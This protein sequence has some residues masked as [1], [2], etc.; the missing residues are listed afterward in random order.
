MQFAGFF[1]LAL[2]YVL[3]IANNYGFRKT[4]EKVKNCFVGRDSAKD[5]KY[6]VMEV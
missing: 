1:V 4:L 2:L 3:D 5:D 6:T